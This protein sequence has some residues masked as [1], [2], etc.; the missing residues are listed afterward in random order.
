MLIRLPVPKLVVFYN[1]TREEPDEM[2]AT[3]ELIVA[4][5]SFRRPEWLQ[6]GME[7]AA[8][9]KEIANN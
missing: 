1:G 9:V 8:V 3:N 7:L 6:T 4:S 2:I 5:P